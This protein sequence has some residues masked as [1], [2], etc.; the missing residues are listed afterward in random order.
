MNLKESSLYIKDK[1]YFTI[2]ESR[3]R[4]DILKIFDT[5]NS[6]IDERFFVERVDKECLV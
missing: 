5:V 4:T 6:I 2:V 1:F 3:L